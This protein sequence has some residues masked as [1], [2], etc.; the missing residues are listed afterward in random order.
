MS[1]K[2]LISISF[3]TFI[4][5]SALYAQV[6]PIQWHFGFENRTDT[7]ILLIKGKIKQ[8]W[9]IYSYDTP[10]GGPI[11]LQIVIN[12]S[13]YYQLGQFIDYSEK[14]SIYD[15]IFNINTIMYKKN[16]LIRQVLIRKT[17]EPFNVNGI[18]ISQ[19]CQADNCS[20]FRDKFDIKINKHP[21]M[22]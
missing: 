5:S 11:P 10:K 20:L 6:S 16:I 21:N 22:R 3:I 9:H 4:L 13:E 14:I 7:V 8:D 19:G 12:S 1:M 17:N 15:K 18:I 2:H